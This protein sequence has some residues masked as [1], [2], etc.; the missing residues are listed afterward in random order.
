MRRRNSDV[1]VKYNSALEKATESINNEAW[2][3]AYN[4]LLSS[5]VR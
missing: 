3:A 4:Y 5:S 1:S 2:A